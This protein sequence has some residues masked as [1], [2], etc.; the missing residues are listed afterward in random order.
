MKPRYSIGILGLLAATTAL[1]FAS[2]PDEASSGNGSAEVNIKVGG[3]QPAPEPEKTVTTTTET[4]QEVPAGPGVAEVK[5]VERE[6][7]KE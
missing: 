1:A 2:R 3:E 6:T 7:H 5:T 4:T